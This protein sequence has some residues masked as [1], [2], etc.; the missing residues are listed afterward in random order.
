[1]QAAMTQRPSLLLASSAAVH[2]AAAIGLL[3]APE[4]ILAWAG[5]PPSTLDSALLQLL[6][7]ASLGFAMLDWM[8]RHSIVGGLFGRPVVVANLAYAGSAALVLAHVAMDTG[9]AAPLGAALL[10]YGSLALA[11]A[12]KLVSGPASTGS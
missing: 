8:Q 11:F 7:S 4:E 1:M 6:G 9:F 10:V 3:F 2:F 5:A 12:L